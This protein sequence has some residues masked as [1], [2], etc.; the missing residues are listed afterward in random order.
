MNENDLDYEIVEDYL[1]E[2]IFLRVDGYYFCEFQKQMLWSLGDIDH[3]KRQMND[4]AAPKLYQMATDLLKSFG[5]KKS[6]DVFDVGDM[7]DEIKSEIEK[8][9]KDFLEDLSN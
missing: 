2:T 9:F 1:G 5:V 8:R 3:L 4:I 6:T 7:T